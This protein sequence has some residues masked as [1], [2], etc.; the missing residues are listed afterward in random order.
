MG[1][2]EIESIFEH[3]EKVKKPRWRKAL[4]WVAGAVLLV[5]VL[6]FVGVRWS[7][8]G[9][10]TVTPLHG[11]AD[12]VSKIPTTVK[13]AP[14]AQ[15]AA[16]D[17][18]KTAVARKDLRRGYALA[19]PQIRQGQTLKEWMTGNIAVVPYPVDDIDFA[20]MKIDY[21]YKNEAL[22]EVALLPKNGAKVRPIIF[23][24]SLV[25]DE[26]GNWLV[27]S[28]VPKASA[29]VHADATQG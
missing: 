8:T 24:M 10:T 4:P 11:A 3:R 5:G 19:G 21:S 27:N 1:E 28:W 9:H 29:P 14:G 26:Q 17:F 20:P 16:R 25:R 22:I 7:N 15:R 12:D 6:V 13:L 2:V 23:S 18:I